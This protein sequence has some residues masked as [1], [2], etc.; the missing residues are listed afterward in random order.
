MSNRS[1]GYFKVEGS[2]IINK[3][4]IKFSKTIRATSESEAEQSVLLHYGSMLDF[5]AQA[6]NDIQKEKPLEVIKRFALFYII[7]LVL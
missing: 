4:K 3:E 5:I 7:L 6:V 2:I 1:I